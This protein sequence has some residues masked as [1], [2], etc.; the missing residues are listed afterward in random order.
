MSNREGIFPL[1]EPHSFV[2]TELLYSLRENCGHE[3]RYIS[4]DT[5]TIFL[6]LLHPTITP[7]L[8]I[9]GFPRDNAD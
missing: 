2:E 1:D 8:G 9:L 3:D 4:I 5:E 6:E 7:C